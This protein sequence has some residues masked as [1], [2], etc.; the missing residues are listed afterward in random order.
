M[1]RAT[2]ISAF[3][4]MGLLMAATTVSAQKAPT[5]TSGGEMTLRALGTE[6]IESSKFTEYREVPKGMSIPFVNL[7]SAGGKVDFNLTGQNVQQTNQRFFGWAKAYGFGVKFDYNQIPHNMG[8]D[9]HLIYNETTP[10]MWT[11]ADN[12]QQAL[13]TAVD[14]RLPTSARTYDFYS[15]LLA[16]VFASTNLIDNSGIRKTGNVELNFGDRL[17]F[18]LSLSYKNEMKEGYRGLGSVN[19]RERVSPSIE[20]LSPMDE[21]IHDI[22]I[23]AGKNFTW[24][25]A[26]A[27]FNRNLYDN[28]AETVVVDFPFQAVDATYIA[29]PVAIGGLSQERFVLAPDNEASTAKAGLLLKFAKQTR[30]NASVQMGTWTQ[31]APFYPYTHNSALNTPAGLSAASYGAL[32]QKSYGGKVNTTMFNLSF[33]SRPVEGLTLRA[34]YRVYDLKDKSNKYVITGD[35][36]GSNSR[37]TTV[38]A[39]ADEPFGHP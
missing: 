23:R 33:A 3:V 8:N 16:P 18:D 1:T 39:D 13:Q 32:Q 2:K 36:S 25:N 10:G 38:T 27:S 5:I 21:I 7:W 35:V 19:F 20:F 37:W 12:L 22:G 34:Q 29:S 11:M 4:A 9:A 30:I 31:D 14:T 28:R 15:A 26:Y 6:D 17:P 24:G